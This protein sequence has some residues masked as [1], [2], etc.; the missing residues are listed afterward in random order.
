MRTTSN[1]LLGQHPHL[2]DEDV[3]L[4]LDGEL[5]PASRASVQKHLEDCWECRAR[6]TE[7]QNTITSFIHF[8]R[9]RF[10]GAFPPIDGPRALLRAQLRQLSEPAQTSS[11]IGWRSLRILHFAPSLAVAALAVFALAILPLLLQHGWRAFSTTPALHGN[12]IDDVVPRRN[13]TPGETIFA[14]LPDVCA[15]DFPTETTITVPVS[16]QRRV[17]ARYGLT[18][19]SPQD[20]QVDF[21]IT[22]DLGGAMSMRNLW[23]EPYGAVMWNA[24]VK[25]RLEMKLKTMVCGGTLDLPTAQ[26]DLATNWIAAYK[27]YLG[28]TAPLVTQRPMT[29][30][31][32]SLGVRSARF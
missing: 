7:L 27:K 12:V 1:F 30:L 2:S 16:L 29:I 10:A 28:N 5:T 17:F 20:F 24:R 32:A 26:H 8:R 15:P 4:F 25:D 13:L 19:P 31:M 11:S 22:P 18:H 21:L 6:S 3:L 9:D 23:P 14:T